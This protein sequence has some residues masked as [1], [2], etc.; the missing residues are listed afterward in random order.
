MNYP[1][2]FERIAGHEPYPY[3][4]RLAAEEW[5]D[6]V[7]VP[8]GLGKTAAMVLAWLWKRLEGLG[9]EPRRL[10]YCLPMRVLVEQTV[11]NARQWVERATSDFEERGLAAPTV[12]TLM[13]GEVDDDWVLHPA[14]PAILVG[15][16]DMLLSRALMRGYAM[17]RYQWP[18]HFALVHNDA[19]WVLDEIQ[20]MGPA[21]ATSAQLEAFRR[22]Q[23]PAF[24]ARTVWMSATLDPTWVSTVDFH[25]HLPSARRLAIGDGDRRGAADR[26]EA[27]KR[28]HRA[29]TQLAKK[30]AGRGDRAYTDALASEVLAS[31]RQGTQTIAILNRVARAQALYRSLRAAAPEGL[32]VILLHARFRASEREAI[33]RSLGEVPAG[34]RVIVGTQAVEAG[35]DLSSATL[36]TELA[37]WASLVQRFGRSNRYGE[38]GGGA[39][40]HWIDI[41]EGTSQALPYDEE[42]L[43]KS[44][45]ILADL[46]SASITDLPPVRSEPDVR[47]VLRRKDFSD[48]FDTEPDLSGFD[49]D[50]SPYIRDPGAPQ[51]Q[52]FWRAFDS[53]P[54][55]ERRPTRNELCPVSMGQMG[56]YLK[57][58]IRSQ[59][60]RFWRWDA[61]GERWVRAAANDRPRPGEVL[62][63]RADAGGYDGAVG[64]EPSLAAEVGVVEPDEAG[65][66]PDGQSDDRATTLG[67]FIS[68]TEHTADVVQEAR[69]LVRDLSLAPDEADRLERA[70][71]WHDLGKAHPAFQTAL[72]D[73]GEPGLAVASVDG[74]PWAKSPG[75]GRLNYR[76]EHD[77]DIEK[78]RYFRHELASLLAWLAQGSGDD[79]VAYMIAAHHGKLRLALR[80]LPD[81]PP[82]PGGRLFARGVWGGDILPAVTVEG[83]AVSETRLSLDVME[84]GVGERGPSWTERTRLLLQHEGPFRLAWLEALLRIADQRASAAERVSAATGSG[85]AR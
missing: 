63:L 71:V 83:L 21:L 51:V 69:A 78:R 34:G 2:F 24:P 18:I 13:G 50:V 23:R 70:A 6:F 7:D 79:G 20:L 59:A 8:T 68:L 14:R 62:L 60:R 10:V 45:V 33:E 72:L 43:Q 77:G 4:A 54:Q 49:L 48:L 1:A 67:R 22:G 80:A 56:E 40:V 44:R 76:I 41:D 19:L 37:P 61:L 81:E 29:E 47:P 9:G 5:P 3:Q 75:R 27:I 15:T 31:H 26:L 53:S 52:V 73:F 74:G 17:S 28:L 55:D 36:F 42:D 32:D 57:K 85:T 82:A 66:T 39:D 65:E 25:P 64:F 84:L 46:D 35:V 30:N 11:R 38:V 16:Q 12:H 58:K